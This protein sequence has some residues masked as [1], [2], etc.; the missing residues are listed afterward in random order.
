MYSWTAGLVSHLESEMSDPHWSVNVKRGVLNLL[1]LSLKQDTES[2]DTGS[3]ELLGEY[4][5][6]N[7]LSKDRASDKTFLVREVIFVVVYLFDIRHNILE[8]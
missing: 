2:R 3:F 5:A 1:H 6:H 4:S 7:L 8:K